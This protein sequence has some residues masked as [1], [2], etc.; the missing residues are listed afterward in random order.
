MKHIRSQKIYHVADSH[1]LMLAERHTFQPISFLLVVVLGLLACGGSDHTEQ[2]QN[3]GYRVDGD[4]IMLSEGSNIS[5]KLH[6]LT[7]DLQLLNAP[8]STT[9]IV[10]VNPNNYAEIAPPFAGRVTRSYVK[11]G[12][13]VSP[14]SPI[15]EI[16]SPD[17]FT[18]QK[19]YFDARQELHQAQ[20]N[21]TRQRDLWS[22]G[23]GVQRELEAAETEFETKKTTLANASAALKIFNVDLASLELGKPLVLSSPIKGEVISSQ[24]VIGQYLKE[25]AEA[26]VVLA[27]LSKIWIAG[28]LKEKDLQHI[29][30]MDQ[31]YVHTAALSGRP[32]LGKIFH[33]NQIVDEETRSVEVL[34]EC[35]NRERFLKP[36]MYVTLSYSDIPSQHILIPTKAVFQR[37]NEQ[38]VFVQVGRDKFHKRTITTGETTDDQI[39]IL[40]GLQAGETIVSEGGIFLLK[41]E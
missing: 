41:A 19:D 12:Q 18:A 8:W 21:L 13:Q 32:L 33:I 27:E 34:I 20:L 39:A 24:I 40:S 25:D 37:E 16:S 10:R 35:D 14:G 31:V 29:H 2:S 7:V 1:S 22:N 6:L 5:P 11:L 36:G 17:F 9:G 30:T 15:F 28:Q 38:F 26:I 3:E 4:T 23:V